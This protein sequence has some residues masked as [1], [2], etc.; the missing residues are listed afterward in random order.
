MHKSETSYVFSPQAADVLVEVAKRFKLR[1]PTYD[2]RVVGHVVVLDR[3]VEDF[4]GRAK[5]ETVRD[6]R[7]KR[8]SV[9]FPETEFQAVIK[10]FGRRVPISVF[11][12]VYPSGSVTELRSPRNLV[13]LA[14][15]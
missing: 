1:Q 3:G 8:F 11:G 2:E 6:G 13:L 10:A 15:E 12:D 14:D 5:I 9:V 7:P 4:D